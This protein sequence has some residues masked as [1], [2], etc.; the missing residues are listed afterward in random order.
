MLHSQIGKDEGSFDINQV[1]EGLSEKLVNRHPHVFGDTAVSGSRQVLENWEQI[2][3]SERSADAGMLDGI[4]AGMPS[5]LKAQR[6]GEKVGRIGFDWDT[7]AE[8]EEKVREELAEFTSAQ[9][10]E[11]GKEKMEEE[12]GDLL[13]SLAQLGRKLG[14]NCEDVLNRACSKFKSRFRHMEQNSRTPLKELPREEL[15]Q[16]WQRAKTAEKH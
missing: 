11:L 6:I 5:M 1:V 15:E 7:P 10:A 12:F 14:M 8:I 3:K 9:Q 16:L 13:F 2:K 4:P